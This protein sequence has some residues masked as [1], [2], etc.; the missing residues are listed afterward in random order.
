MYLSMALGLELL[1]SRGVDLESSLGLEPGEEWNEP[2]RAAAAVVLVFV[3][4]GGGGG[5]SGPHKVELR[6]PV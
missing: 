2:A 1:I 4:V 5:G 6:A 3:F